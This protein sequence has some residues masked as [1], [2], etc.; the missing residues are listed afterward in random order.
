MAKFVLPRGPISQILVRA[1]SH[2]FTC[3]QASSCCSSAHSPSLGQIQSRCPQFGP[4]P[5]L[6]AAGVPV[7]RDGAR[8]RTSLVAVRAGPAGCSAAH[9]STVSGSGARR[10]PCRRGAVFRVVSSMIHM[11]IV[12][13]IGGNR[14]EAPTSKNPSSVRLI[15][16][17]VP[18]EAN[19]ARCLD[20]LW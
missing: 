1:T 5:A 7:L 12:A 15:F 18:G 4:V 6:R 10:S 8:G 9:V 20:R 16:R 11:G 13:A 19:E 2:M 17:K 14:A 3:R